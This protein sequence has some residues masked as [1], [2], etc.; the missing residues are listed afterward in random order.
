MISKQPI[1]TQKD[2][3][4]LQS[5]EKHKLKSWFDNIAANQNDN[6]WAGCEQRE[7]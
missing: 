2:A 5:S 3:Q 6:Y 1:S 4:L 7:L